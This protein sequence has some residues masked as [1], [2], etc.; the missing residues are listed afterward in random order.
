MDILPYELF[1]YIIDYDK[2]ILFELTS[3][4]KLL[5]SYRNYFKIN[6]DYLK[7]YKFSTKFQIDI[8]FNVNS[9]PI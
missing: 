7:I 1:Q 2:K 6:I 4:N 3:L 8:L 5:Y 9:L